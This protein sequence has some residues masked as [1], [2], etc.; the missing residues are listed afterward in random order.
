MQ[1]GIFTAVGGAAKKAA[2][3]NITAY[4]LRPLRRVFVA[5]VF[6]TP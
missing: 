6:L 2:R 4:S 3:E 5:F 1:K